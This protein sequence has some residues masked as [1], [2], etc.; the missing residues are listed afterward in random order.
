MTAKQSD[1]IR[2]RREI[3]C[4]P[5]INRGELWRQRL[6]QEQKAELESWYQKWLDAPKTG[7]IPNMPT[8]IN[9]KTKAEEILL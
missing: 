3:E 9:C 8:W 1:Y 4:F 2:Q 5:I 6:T 7:N